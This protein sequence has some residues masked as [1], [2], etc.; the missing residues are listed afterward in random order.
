MKSLWR[1]LLVS[2]L[3]LPGSATWAFDSEATDTKTSGDGAAMGTGETP[4]ASSSQPKRNSDDLRG[5]FVANTTCDTKAVT[6]TNSDS[7]LLVNAI[8]DAN[9]VDRRIP[10]MVSVV[11]ERYEATISMFVNRDSSSFDSDSKI[12]ALK[13][14]KSILDAQPSLTLAKVQFKSLKCNDY[15]EIVVGGGDVSSYNA[16]RRSKEDIANSLEVVAVPITGEQ[17]QTESNAANALHARLN[18]AKNGDAEKSKTDAGSAVPG[19]SEKQAASS[20]K[21]ARAGD[22]IA[23]VAPVVKPVEKV[24][25]GLSSAST[26]TS[27]PPLASTLPAHGPKDKLFVW[28]SVAFYYP[29]RWVQRRV[30][31]NAWS[32]PDEDDV[33]EIACRTRTG[34]AQVGLARFFRISLAERLRTESELGTAFDLE[35]TQPEQVRFGSAKQFVGQSLLSTGRE[36]KIYFRRVYFQ[37]GHDLYAL[38][39]RCRDVE[40]SACEREFMRM[41]ATVYMPR[42][43]KQLPK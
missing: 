10:V 39:L 29:Q 18:K 28:N 32:T 21:S 14:A 9:A 24:D 27:T 12:A 3:T 26:A 15:K 2:L 19:A 31:K 16:G 4:A 22:A 8:Y 1:V 5:E 17:L 38:T 20:S 43:K 25:A 34:E 11:P 30:S 42:Q 41:L 37:L 7:D 35:V 23:A 40:A 33:A 13:I 6:D 36:G